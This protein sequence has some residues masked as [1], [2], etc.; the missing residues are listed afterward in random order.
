MGALD[1]NIVSN[2][3]NNM[4]TTLPFFILL[5]TSILLFSLSC[6]KP[7]EFT[8]YNS[9]YDEQSNAYIPAPDLITT[10]VHSIRALDAWAGGEFTTDYG[11]A[12]T[13][14]GVCWDTE[15]QPS[16]EDSCTNNGEGVDAFESQLT[17]LEPDQMYYVRAYAINADTTI[18]GDQREFT[19]RGY[20]PLTI[21]IEGQGEVIQEVV[22][23]K[24][25]DY[26]YGTQVQL[27]AVPEAKWAFSSW[28]GDTTA[29]QETIMIEVDGEK[30]LTATFYLTTPQLT[31]ASI[32]GITTNSAQ[33]GGNI[34][35]DGGA[36]VTERGVCWSTSQNPTTSD[37]CTSDGSGTGSFTSS[38]ESLNPD[39]RYYVRAYASTSLD[40]G[41]GE[42]VEFRTKDGRPG[43]STLAVTN[44]TTYSAQSGGSITDDGGAEVTDRGV[45][46]STSQNPTT[47]DSCS[48]DGSGTGSFTSSLEDLNQDTKY[49]VRA[50]AS[51]NLDTDYGQQLEF[52]T[53]DGR[54]SNTTI[55]EVTS[56]TG[57]TW[58]DRNLGASRAATSKDDEKA[59][60]DLYQWGRGADGHQKRNSSSQFA[61]GPNSD[62]LSDS[63]QPGHGN[64]IENGY[65][66]KDWRNPQNN[67]LWQDENGINNPCPTGY[68]LPTEDEWEEEMNSWS[69]ETTEAAFESPLKLPAAGVRGWNDII[70]GTG[71]FGEYW[72]S[73]IKDTRAVS[74]AIFG[75]DALLPYSYRANGYS[76][77]CIK[78]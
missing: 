17:E 66:P 49:Y 31:T 37:S 1:L 56:A 23:P 50:Y 32:S 33:S 3:K 39:T 60:G 27:S 64:F 42:Q 26:L 48:S 52:R 5:V 14:K 47:S 30:E 44:I 43:L 2:A 11:K 76:V 70:D 41:Y 15:E 19:T 78:D 8:D 72:S 24:T 62:V 75:W 55:V 67:N 65:D 20:N 22:Q 57:R 58:M 73:T 36:E 4:K 46:W 40:T 63:D 28:S 51:T 59:Y 12:V 6:E 16:T 71:S 53:S 25:T 35:N 45:C 54:D 68:R 61:L 9:P 10:E 69:S 29:T 34:T 38:I 18:Y 13:A 21:S 74:L 77:R 7:S